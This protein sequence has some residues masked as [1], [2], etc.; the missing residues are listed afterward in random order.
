MPDPQP[1]LT[2][3]P[4][5]PPPPLHTHLETA[6]TLLDLATALGEVCL[7]EPSGVDAAE[8]DADAKLVRAELEA[9]FIWLDEKGMLKPGPAGNF[10]HLLEMD[11]VLER[12]ELAEA[13][14]PVG[15]LGILNGLLRPLGRMY[16]ETLGVV[17]VEKGT[18]V[19]VPDR[20]INA[21]FRTT[22]EPEGTSG[23]TRLLSGT[24]FYVFDFGHDAGVPVRLDFSARHRLD[25]LLWSKKKKLP[26]IATIHP[27][28]KDGVEFESRSSSFF[29]V[30]P[31]LWDPE[32][33]TAQLRKGRRRGRAE[34]GILPELSLPNADSLESQIASNSDAF[35]PLI[36]AGSAHVREGKGDSEVRANE[37]RIY[38]DGERIGRH[39][40][41]HPFKLGRMPNGEKLPHPLTEDLTREPKPITIFAGKATRMAVMICSDL[42]GTK[43]AAQ[44]EDARV[45]LLLVP[46]L[47]PEPGSFAGDVCRLASHC[48]GVSV[49]AN[50][51]GSLFEY[52]RRP[53][54]V[55]AAVPR[56]LI[57]EQAREYRRRFRGAPAVGVFNPNR[58]LRRAL[59]WL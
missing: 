21:L 5:K 39:R 47:T 53:F 41:I 11:E 12:L 19:P 40:K 43:L 37:A 18:P 33:V 14:H 2:V 48:Q 58:R 55:M 10:A 8:N 26:R 56:P 38:L 13:F 45:N 9:R 22:P 27:R 49:V 34:V 57:R 35:P 54:M 24:G 29:G 20:P 46:A 28:L 17:E 42:I 44:L 16:E 4:R 7:D 32:A 3:R 52:V 6:T 31:R 36:V 51:D 25:E 15:E 23:Y 1:A 50:G 30:K 59:K